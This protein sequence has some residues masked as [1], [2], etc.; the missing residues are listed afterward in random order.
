MVDGSG[1]SDL[2]FCS[3]CPTHMDREGKEIDGDKMRDAYLDTFEKDCLDKHGKITEK[4]PLCHKSDKMRYTM[5]SSIG[6]VGNHCDRCDHDTSSPWTCPG[7]NKDNA[8]KS[9][10]KDGYMQCEHCDTKFQTL[11]AHGSATKEERDRYHC[12]DCGKKK[13]VFLIA[14][15]PGEKEP[16]YACPRCRSVFQIKEAG[17]RASMM[18]VAFFGGIGH[19]GGGSSSYV[20][21]GG[22][23]NQHI[24]DKSFDSYLAVKSYP[25]PIDPERNLEKRLEMF[26]DHAEEDLIPYHLSFKERQRLKLRQMIHQKEEN[27]ARERRSIEENSPSFIKEHFQPAPE[28]MQTLETSLSNLHRYKVDQ[29]FKYE[30]ECPPQDPP[31]RRHQVL[32]QTMNR[33]TGTSVFNSGED[34]ESDIKPEM[35]DRLTERGD[36]IQQPV[37]TQGANLDDYLD[38]LASAD[39]LQ[40]G[41]HGVSRA[42]DAMD[43]S[44]GYHSVN[45]RAERQP[46]PS[47]DATKTQVVDNAG[48]T[49]EQKLNAIGRG[50]QTQQ[51]PN[52]P[53]HSFQ[54]VFQDE[55]QPQ[56]PSGVMGHGHSPKM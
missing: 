15:G 10:G 13:G 33:G 12:P 8:I 31:Q 5:L 53:Y 38:D 25:A 11:S 16:Q 20:G 29:K 7:C 46:E 32:S 54:N 56:E 55:K 48:M 9:K 50:K 28:Q 17:A 39:W 21:G 37:L 26:H 19:S 3:S 4:C 41:P 24:Q 35:R 1:I 27:L 34:D 22:G 43:S 18:R 52:D 14:R 36:N 23:I 47:S 51:L 40:D 2:A 49:A 45:P 44:N 30:D 42:F 6:G